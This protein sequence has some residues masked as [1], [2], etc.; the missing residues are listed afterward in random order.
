VLAEPGEQLPPDGSSAGPAADEDDMG[1]TSPAYPTPAVVATQLRG[2]AEQTG[3]PQHLPGANR[4]RHELGSWPA[5]SGLIS[6]RCPA[7]DRWAASSLLMLWLPK[8]G[9]RRSP[10]STAARADS[11]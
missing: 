9:K 3:V 6:P 1:T 8:R 7:P 11:A 10:A 5:S 4:H 2:G